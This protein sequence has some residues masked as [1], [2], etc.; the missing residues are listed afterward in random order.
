[1]LLQVSSDLVMDVRHVQ[2]DG[3][4]VP[5]Y[6]FRPVA[7]TGSEH[8]AQVDGSPAS[9]AV[10]HSVLEPPARGC[11]GGC[12]LCEPFREAYDYECPELISFQKLTSLGEV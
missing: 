2:L 1:M 3:I 4:G 7:K 12:R 6:E 11:A 8:D 9:L 5:L 10:S